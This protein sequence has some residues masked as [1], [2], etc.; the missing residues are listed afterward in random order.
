MHSRSALIHIYTLTIFAQIAVLN[1]EDQFLQQPTGSNVSPKVRSSNRFYPYFKDCVGA[2]DGTR[3]RVKVSKDGAPRY[4]GKYYLV[5]GG[6]MLRSGLIAPYRGVCYHLKEYSSHPP[7]NSQELFNIRHA[8]L[9]NAIERVFGVLK[10]RFPIIGSTT[11]P[12]YST[13]TQSSITLAY[14]TLH[15]YLIG[16]DPNESLIEEV[17]KEISNEFE[18]SEEVDD[19]PI[20]VDET[21]LK[22][23]TIL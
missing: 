11:E 1:Q 3:V 19:A 4:R 15:N 23:T 17:D 8:S 7:Q 6:Y 5:D 16:V 18:E 9:S 10:K 2:I 14:C 12:N 22:F 20:N 21:I 13:N